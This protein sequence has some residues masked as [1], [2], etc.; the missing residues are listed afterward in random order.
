MNIIKKIQN[1][2]IYLLLNGSIIGILAGLA[3]ALFRYML[4]AAGYIN[5]AIA[6]E[7]AFLFY[8]VLLAFYYAV[9]VLCLK[10]DSSCSGSGI[11]RVKGELAGRLDTTWYKALTT[12]LIGSVCTIGSGMSMGQVGPSAQLGAMTAKGFSRLTKGLK[13]HEALFMAAGAGAGFA[14]VLNAPLAGILFAFEEINKRFSSELLLTSL[15]ACVVSDFITSRLLNLEPLFTVEISATLPVKNWWLLIIFGA[16]T[17]LAGILYNRSIKLLQGCYKRIKILWLRMLVPIG[18]AAALTLTYPYV[19]SDGSALID[20]LVNGNHTLH[21]L[22][23]LLLVKYI[24]TIVCFGSG[25]PGG[26]I[27]PVLVIGALMGC[28]FANAAGCGEYPGYFILLGMSGYFTAITRTP[29]TGIILMSEISGSLAY[30]PSIAL[31]CIISYVTAA[32]MKSKP[33]F[34]QLLENILKSA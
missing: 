17:G 18:A 25:A 29:L 13:N 32:L 9:I 23:I 24:F 10:L 5:E 19:L 7:G 1:M 2:Q 31:V 4:I 6:D 12:M 3:V 16:V 22:I 20:D 21:A 30:L 11:P 33:I 15:T 26:L 34:D 8:P 28:L 14:A 27:G